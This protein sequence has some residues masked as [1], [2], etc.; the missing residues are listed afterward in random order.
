MVGKSIAY[1][2]IV[3]VAV[4]GICLPAAAQ[5][6]DRWG[7]AVDVERYVGLYD[8]DLGRSWFVAEA[9]PPMGGDA[10]IPEDHLMVGATFGDVAPWYMK[11]LSDAEFIRPGFNEYNPD[12]VVTFEFDGEG[13]ATA[14]TFAYGDDAPQTWLRSGNLPEDWQ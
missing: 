2:V 9:E 4:S 14:L 1:P 5:E 6:V 12:I 11:T 7:E 10:P 3:V 13:N 8:D